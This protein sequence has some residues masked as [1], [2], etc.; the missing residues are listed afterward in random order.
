MKGAIMWCH[1]IS[2][3]LVSAVA[4]YLRFTGLGESS[5]TLDESTM[6]EFA[7]GVMANGYP[8][9]FVG[10]MEVP[11]A[12]YELVP[13]SIAAA[14]SL[15]GVSDF[16]ARLPSAAFGTATAVLIYVLGARWFDW[17]VGLSAGLFYALSPWA[18]Y[19][20]HNCFHPN[21]TQFFAL[22]TAVQVRAI[23]AND[24][25]PT[26]TYYLAA[27]CFI[28]TY[29]SWEGS[30]FLLPIL[31]VVAFI[32]RWGRWQW[33]NR[34]H[35]WIASIIV[36][37]VVVAQGVRR[38]LLQTGYLMVGS[39]KSDMSLPQLVFTE[40]GYNPF[41]YVSIIFGIESHIVLGAVFV[42][43]LALLLR[44]W[45]IRF[46]Y[47]YTLVAIVCMTNL[48][49]YYNSH[50]IYYVLP[51]FF[52]AVAAAVVMGLDVLL[53][54]GGAMVRLASVR[55]LHGG[56]VVA[57]VALLLAST[58]PYGLKPYHMADTYKAPRVFQFRLGLAGIDYRGLAYSL[59]DHYR[60]GDKIIAMTPLALRFYTGLGG[61]YFLQSI[62]GRKVV[63]DPNAP[64]PVYV[65]KF[66]GNP[67]LR[68][69][70]DLEDVLARHPR[71]WLFAVPFFGYTDVV[72]KDLQAFIN[73]NFR[74]V[75]ESYDGR[76]YLWER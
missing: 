65:D 27:L 41:Y 30:G 34:P 20:A 73:S 14:M 45:N 16:A 1:V 69:R 38:S 24:H 36:V 11:L 18:I 58:T 48:L 63:F 50:Y 53:R 49:G 31:L 8:S 72:D 26:R 52:L 23:L 54:Q 61:D 32:M 68:S 17:R 70:A 4:A 15:F 28:C 75:T 37:A 40:S 9:I 13:Y 33:L 35:L 42:L 6:A 67:V 12:T 60:A 47:L 76:L 62:T 7:K 21:Q 3:A 5:L 74:V 29:L 2:A 59:R 56:I 43:G 71:V 51:A 64:T 10:S 46:V 44:D 19:W 55:V 22:L 66:A 25:V 57:A 39:G